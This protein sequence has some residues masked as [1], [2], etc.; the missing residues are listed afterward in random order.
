MTSSVYFS[1]EICKYMCWTMMLTCSNWPSSHHQVGVLKNIC[2]VGMG[3][4]ALL[5]N[6]ILHPW[7]I[8]IHPWTPKTCYAFGLNCLFM[9]SL[10][11]DFEILLTVIGLKLPNFWSKIYQKGLTMKSSIE[12]KCK[13]RMILKECWQLMMEGDYPQYVTSIFLWKALMT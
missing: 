7:N 10:L 6:M 5:V 1:L 9:S 12:I 2:F 13:T 11:D 4:D 3:D 8:H